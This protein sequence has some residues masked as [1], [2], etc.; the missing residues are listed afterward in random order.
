MT[1]PPSLFT[2]PPPPPP[3]SKMP[4]TIVSVKASGYEQL[5]LTVPFRAIMNL[6]RQDQSV[7]AIT[8]STANLRLYR[9]FKYICMNRNFYI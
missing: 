3:S 2:K 9:N 1:G 7:V 5:P 8:N 4:A 6:Q